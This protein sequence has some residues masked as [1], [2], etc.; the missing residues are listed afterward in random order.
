[1]HSVVISPLSI[2]IL[3]IGV[4]SRFFPISLARSVSL[5]SFSNN[6][7]VVSVIFLCCFSVFY[8]IVFY[9]NLDCF[10]SL[11]ALNLVSSSIS[12]FFWWMFELL[13]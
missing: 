11:L 4:F 12:S 1:M 10:L 2:L 3:I 5:L 6:Q 8:F 9:S 13:I 7:L